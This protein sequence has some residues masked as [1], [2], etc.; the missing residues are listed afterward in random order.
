MIAVPG[1]KKEPPG[2]LKEIFETWAEGDD[3][4]LFKTISW[5]ET[6]LK[7]ESD[8]LYEVTAKEAECFD[9]AW[10]EWFESGHEFAVRDKEF[11]DQGLSDIL[12]FILIYVKRR[13]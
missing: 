5:W 11:L 7:E 1:L 12:N 2:H 8:G 10:R 9:I 4:E 3:A 6:L 13:A